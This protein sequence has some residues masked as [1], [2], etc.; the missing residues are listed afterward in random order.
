MKKANLGIF[1]LLTFA[2]SAGAQ[3]A[4]KTLVC[5]AKPQGLEAPNWNVR[6]AVLR[7]LSLRIFEQRLNASAIALDSDTD[8]HALKEAKEKKCDLVVYSSID[9]RTG[10]ITSTMAPSPFQRGVVNPEATPGIYM[11]H[12]ALKFSDAKKNESSKEKVQVPIDPNYTA[13]DLEKQGHDL[14]EGVVS[15]IVAAIPKQ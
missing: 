6:P 12:Y 13:K 14:I 9:R 10:E 4:P 11:L 5:L 8:K 3:N 15:K 7:Q 1:A 2:I